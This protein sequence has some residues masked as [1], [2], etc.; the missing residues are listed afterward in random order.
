MGI[1]Q[2]N[3]PGKAKQ[4][5]WIIQQIANG[6]G[7]KWNY[8]HPKE[9][10]NEMTQCMP[11]IRGITWDRLEE[12]HS[13]T[14]PCD[15]AADPGQPVIFTNDFPTENG[16]A[17]FVKSPLINA[18]ELPDDEFPFV[19]IT[20][21]QLE[22]W[23]TGSMTRRASMLHEIEPDP[24]ANLCYEDMQKLG[25]KDGDLISVSSRRGEIDVY[26]RRDDMLKSGQVFIPFCYVESAANLLTNAALDP[27]A[28]IPEFKFCAVRIQKILNI[29]IA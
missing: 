28:K 10:F 5:L 11:S 6:I 13:I 12:S 9:I 21:R 7:L 20:G 3:P 22:H 14:Y 24:N 16:K 8:K 25:I 19:L 15:D 4:D 26:A 2:L 23:H 1:K 17:K 18:A 29:N 27:F